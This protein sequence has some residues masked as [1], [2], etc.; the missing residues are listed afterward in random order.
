M[1]AL[2]LADLLE[3]MGH[4]VCASVDTAIEAVIAA[5]AFRPDLIITDGNLREGSGVAA[6][7]DILA[8]EFIPHI[9]VTGDPFRLATDRGAIVVQKPFTVQTLTQAI[10]RATHPDAQAGQLR[11]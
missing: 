11:A 4:T 6:I 5:A 3:G 10:T 9:F 7:R 2:L 8:I 1:I